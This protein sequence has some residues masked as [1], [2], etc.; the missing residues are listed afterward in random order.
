VEIAV[1]A[2]VDVGETIVAAAVVAAAAKAVAVSIAKNHL[3]R[4]RRRLHAPANCV[5]SFI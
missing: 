3:P 5:L 1:A 2:A 4:F